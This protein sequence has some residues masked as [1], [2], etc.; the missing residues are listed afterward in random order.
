M[1]KNRIET[2]IKKKEHIGGNTIPNIREMMTTT[3][4]NRF[5]YI[6]FRLF[7]V[8]I[9]ILGW[10]YLVQWSLIFA[11]SLTMVGAGACTIQGY[12]RFFVR[13]FI[14]IRKKSHSQFKSHS[15][16]IVCRNFIFRKLQNP[17]M[18]LV[19]F[20]LCLTLSFSHTRSMNVP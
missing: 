1:K 4:L 15:N 18:R 19:S 20:S 3:L 14:S 16:V 12:P 8:F 10:I 13:Q 2:K 6:R 9:Q 17:V 11:V 7:L 5:W